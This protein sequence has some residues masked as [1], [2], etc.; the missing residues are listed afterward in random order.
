MIGTTGCRIESSRRKEGVLLIAGD[1]NRD[2][3][4]HITRWAVENRLLVFSPLSGDEMAAL[5]GRNRCD[6]LYVYDKS[7]AGSIG[8]ELGDGC[9][10]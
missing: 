10:T 8:N 5:T 9:E 4:E 7:L 2:R 6:I 1:M 3:A